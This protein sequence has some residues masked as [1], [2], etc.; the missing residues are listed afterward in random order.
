MMH[1]PVRL[2]RRSARAALTTAIS[3]GLLIVCTPSVDAVI[4]GL[5]DGNQ[6]PNVGLIVGY[7]SQGRGLYSCTGTLVNQTTVLTAAHC[8]GGEN[9]G[10]PIARIVV[11]FDDHLRQLP[12]GTY[13]IDHFVEGVGD[14]DPRYK[15]LAIT[16]GSGGTK[17]FLANSAYDIGL[18]HLTRRADTVFRGIQPAPITA[19]GT[20]QQYQTGTTKDTVLQVGYGVQR[21]GAPGLPDSRFVDYTRNQ[22]SIQPRKLTDS[23][24][25]FGA[26]PNDALGFGSPCSGDSGS[27]IFRQGI[28]IS[29]FAFTQSNCQNSVGGPRL[30]AGPARD[31]LRSRGLVR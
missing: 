5:P 13:Q 14:F 12:D 30:D 31:F 28:I 23:L 11:V 6:H 15:D 20:N 4:G 29:I 19:A 26:N 22:S 27:P 25:F 21:V 2:W 9:F 10:A 17:A 24:L 16:S 3:V 1:L 8:A 18:V 7:D